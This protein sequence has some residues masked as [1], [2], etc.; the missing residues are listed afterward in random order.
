[1]D[2]LKELLDKGIFPVQLPPGFT[3]KSYSSKYKKFKGQWESKKAPITR[4]E[5]FSVARP[6]LAGASILLFS[7]S[8]CASIVEI[9]NINRDT[10]SGLDWLDVTESIG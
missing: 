10:D 8:T 7:F 9:G 1:M 5:K 6:A 4:S 3:S 2:K